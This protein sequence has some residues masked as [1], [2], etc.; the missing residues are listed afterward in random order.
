[1]QIYTKKENAYDVLCSIKKIGLG[2]CNIEFIKKNN[3]VKIICS[4][5]K[6]KEDKKLIKL[7]ACKKIK[8]N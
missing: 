8:I 2:N 1:M 6:T 5:A 4:K 7:I 3:Y